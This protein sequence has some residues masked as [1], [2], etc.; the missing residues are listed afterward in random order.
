MEASLTTGKAVLRWF[1]RPWI[2]GQRHGQF[3]RGHGEAWSTRGLTER[4]G[5]RQRQTREA[6]ENYVD[7]VGLRTD[8]ITDQEIGRVRAS[9][10]AWC[11]PSLN[12]STQHIDDFDITSKLLFPHVLLII[13]V[14]FCIFLTKNLT[15]CSFL[16]CFFWTNTV[17][18]QREQKD[19][20][21]AKLSVPWA[22]EDSEWFW[23]LYGGIKK[24]FGPNLS[25]L[26]VRFHMRICGFPVGVFF[27]CF[28]L[29][30]PHSEKLGDFLLQRHR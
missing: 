13:L 1:T 21:T 11:P 28:N 14:N 15:Y 20:K 16:Y 19:H 18:W 30:F 29:E 4:S 23:D 5:I 24:H 27:F 7:V 3:R 17:G 12:I 9:W 2:W 22:G 6:W 25:V 10:L 26:S 8:W